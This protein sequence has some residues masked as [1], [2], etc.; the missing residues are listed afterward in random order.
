M[1][2]YDFERKIGRERFP[3]ED[4]LGFARIMQ[5]DGLE[6]SGAPEKILPP[7]QVGGH[8]GRHFEGIIFV[9]PKARQKRLHWTCKLRVLGV[10]DHARNGEEKIFLKAVQEGARDGEPEAVD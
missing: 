3:P 8:L 10:L 4:G 2:S 5:P 7:G 9:I 6:Q 1:V